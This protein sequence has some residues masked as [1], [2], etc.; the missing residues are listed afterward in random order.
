MRPAANHR[1]LTRHDVTNM[2]NGL[3][4]D[5]EQK[6]YAHCRVSARWYAPGRARTRLDLRYFS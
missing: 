3:M 5:T 6:R 4:L 1:A 2:R